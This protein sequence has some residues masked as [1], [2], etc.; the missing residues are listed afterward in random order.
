ME[1]IGTEGFQECAQARPRC[2]DNVAS[3]VA[4]PP[5]A[6]ISPV[7]PVKDVGLDARLLT[8]RKG[9][10]YRHLVPTGAH[11]RS[12][13]VDVTLRPAEGRISTVGVDQQDAH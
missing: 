9:A 11:A 8:L 5:H 13:I 7:R 10:Q 6:A 3:M 4:E 12:Q 2:G 1:E